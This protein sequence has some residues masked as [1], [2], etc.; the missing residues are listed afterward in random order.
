MS[1]PKP[2]LLD[3]GQVLQGAFDETTGRLRTDA[4][5]TIVNADIDVQLD[6]DKDGVYIGDKLTGDAARVD[7]DGN[8][9]VKDETVVA[10][11]QNIETAISGVYGQL[12][13]QTA[14][15]NNAVLPDGSFKVT[16]TGGFTPANYD[17]LVIERDLDDDPSFYKFYLNNNLVST[18]QVIYNTN[19][20]AIQYK[21]V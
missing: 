19:K 4:E 10:E 1:A 8:L 7:T 21:K 20:L 13:D 15:L 12:E 2:T 16:V 17:D 18:I 3:A 9:S 6:P 5:A 11:L 14:I